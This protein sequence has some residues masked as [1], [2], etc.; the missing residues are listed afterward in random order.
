MAAARRIL[1]QLTIQDLEKKFVGYYKRNIKASHRHLI[2]PQTADKVAKSFGDLHKYVIIEKDPGPG[3]LTKALLNA[4]CTQLVA[5]ES[6][7]KFLSVLKELEN[8]SDGRLKAYYSDI[9]KLDLI[10]LYQGYIPPVYQSGDIL[11]HIKPKSWD[12]DIVGRVIGVAN[13]TMGH[14]FTISYLIRLIERSGLHRWGRWQ[15]IAYYTEKTARA[16]YA[17]VGTPIYGRITVLSNIL[18]NIS[19]LSK[20]H[21]DE[22]FPRGM[23]IK[24]NSMELICLETKKH[25]E[26][27]DEA[28]KFLDPILQQVFAARRQPL[29]NRLESIAPGSYTVLE[30]LKIPPRKCASN[31]S[32]MDFVEL[33]EAFSS[34][35]GRMTIFDSYL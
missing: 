18:C 16:L 27:S 14:R 7:Q 19:T 15:H 9:N 26:L 2:N 4:G 10:P 29:L 23:A 8:D 31:M 1:P 6:N 5:L 28:L 30:K 24:G 25:C 35:D 17:H 13:N 22:F 12:D 34:W 3:V 33:A 11:G 32:P 21:I 20:D